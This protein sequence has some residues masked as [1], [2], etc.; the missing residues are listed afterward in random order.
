MGSQIA[1]TTRLVDTVTTPMLLKTVQS[2]KIDATKLITYRFK[3]GK[4][5]EAYETFGDAA[6]TGALKGLDRIL[7]RVPSR[8][9]SAEGIYGQRS[10]EA[11]EQA[12]HMGAPTTAAAGVKDL[13][14][15]AS[16]RDPEGSRLL[17]PPIGPLFEEN[18]TRFSRFRRLEIDYRMPLRAAL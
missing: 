1:I 9:R 4:I 15:P 11:R 2:H 12:E 5:L 3:F 13:C 14:Q 6:N 16:T 7:E 10:L 17:R 18:G 8:I